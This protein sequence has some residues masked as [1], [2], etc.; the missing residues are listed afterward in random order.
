MKY[1]CTFWGIFM[2]FES[3][4]EISCHVSIAMYFGAQPASFGGPHPSFLKVALWARYQ[5]D[6]RS[7]KVKMTQNRKYWR[8][9]LIIGR[10]QGSYYMTNVIFRLNFIKYVKSQRNALFWLVG[11]VSDAL[12]WSTFFLSNFVSKLSTMNYVASIIGEN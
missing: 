1:K 4:M 5:I 9:N 12:A 10:I 11:E 2:S 3:Q 7:A 8:R 6:L